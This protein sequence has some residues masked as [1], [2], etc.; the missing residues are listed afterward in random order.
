MLIIRDKLESRE[1]I[2]NYQVYLNQRKRNMKV[3][4]KNEGNKFNATTI[5]LKFNLNKVHD[6]LIEPTDLKSSQ[7]SSRNNQWSRTS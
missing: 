6:Q 4:Q 3:K 1:V 7:K 2:D 5:D